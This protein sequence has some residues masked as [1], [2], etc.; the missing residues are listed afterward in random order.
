[1]LCASCCA[2]FPMSDTFICVSAQLPHP[3]Q[4][5]KYVQ[6][7]WQE[8]RQP[9]VRETGAPSLILETSLTALLMRPRQRFPRMP[10]RCLGSKDFLLRSTPSAA[11]K[12]GAS[13][14][15]EDNF[16]GAGSD[17][18]RLS[19][20]WNSSSFQPPFPPDD[21]V[22]TTLLVSLPPGFQSPPLVSDADC[23][24]SGLRPVDCPLRTRVDDAFSC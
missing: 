13:S 10:Q 15:D 1:M 8:A 20:P 6:M 16:Q 11:A 14:G 12:G 24:F 23:S 21:R 5:N 7:F 17:S 4:P 3:F 9:G 2:I 18:Q 22:P 19:T